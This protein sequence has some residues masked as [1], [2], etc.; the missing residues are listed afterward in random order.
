MENGKELQLSQDLN[1]ITAEI[2]SYKQVA[3]QAIFEIGRRLKHVKEND[4]VH[5]EWE[6]YC[7]ETLEMTPAYAN[8]YIKVFDEFKN[9]NQYTSIGL[10]KL[11]QIATLP[12][13]ERKKEHV[14]SKGETKTVDE[15]TVRELQEVKRK[16]KQT[17]Q[18]LKEEQS[19][20]PKIIEKEV[21]KE[22]D[23]TDYDQINLLRDQ[24]L[25][26]DEHYSELENEL[27]QLKQDTQEYQQLEEN[28]Q[29]LYRDKEKVEE[30][31]KAATS[32]SKL[33]VDV[34]KFV[35]EK[36]GGVKYTK[37]VQERIDSYVVQENLESI[38]NLL[39]KAGQDVLDLLPQ[40]Q[41]NKD[42]I[43]MDIIEE[44]DK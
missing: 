3:G 42:I 12:E 23:N 16:L 14:T 11:Y 32:I 13:K 39:I 18:Q 17:E 36:V 25:R 37:A 35:K 21:I 27:K 4:L 40:F 20:E 41:K 30:Q 44:M 28:L 38:G 24:L 9:S 10:S 6:S 31:I 34:E 43:E 8:R 5:G 15:M 2:N 22:I 29:Q 26:K 33:V 7:S 1:V 19:K